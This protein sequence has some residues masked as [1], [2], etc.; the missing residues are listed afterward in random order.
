MGLCLMGVPA[1]HFGITGSSEERQKKREGTTPVTRR[2]GTFPRLIAKLAAATLF[3]ELLV[4][5]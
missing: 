4:E 5:R 1:E 3:V 2:H